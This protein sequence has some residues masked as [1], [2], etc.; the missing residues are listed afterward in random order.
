MALQDQAAVIEERGWVFFDRGLVDA[1]TA[2][3]HMTAEPVIEALCRTYRYNRHVFLAP[4]WPEIHTIDRERRH[5]LDEA[6]AEYE[7]LCKVYPA[8]GYAV[9]VLPKTPVEDRANFVLTVLEE[10]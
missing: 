7:R 4:P 3:E 10:R 8:L 2:L 1:A 6:I 9:C 5:S